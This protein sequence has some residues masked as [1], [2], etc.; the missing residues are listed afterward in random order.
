LGS[1]PWYGFILQKLQ[2]E[3]KRAG[4]GQLD[5]RMTCGPSLVWRTAL[6]GTNGGF[7]LSEGMVRGRN[8]RNLARFCK[9]V[10]ATS[11]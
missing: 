3:R 6:W 10:R 2:P 7:G 9:T 5:L 1:L 8:P 11:K 4:L